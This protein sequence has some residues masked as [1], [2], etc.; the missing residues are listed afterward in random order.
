L[1][2]FKSNTLMTET[3]TPCV[4]MISYYCIYCKYFLHA[5]LPAERKLYKQIVEQNELRSKKEE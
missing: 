2:L 3:A 4:Q 5:V 1:N